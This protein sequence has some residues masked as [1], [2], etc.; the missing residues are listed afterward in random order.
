[1]HPCCLTCRHAHKTAK[2]PA[3]FVVC[4][5]TQA[6]KSVINSCSSYDHIRNENRPVFLPGE[7]LRWVGLDRYGSVTRTET[8]KSGQLNVLDEGLSA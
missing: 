3:G 1:M 8:A 7:P 5:M 2:T 4:W 6:Q